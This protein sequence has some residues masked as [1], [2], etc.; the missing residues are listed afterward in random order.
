M[1]SVLTARRPRLTDAVTVAD[2]Y[3]RHRGADGPRSRQRTGPD[4]PAPR[5]PRRR[6][7]RSSSSRMRP[8]I[9]PRST[10]R[11]PSPLHASGGRPVPAV[12]LPWLPGPDRAP[13]RP[14]RIHVPTRRPGWRTA[15]SRT[16]SASTPSCPAT[17]GSRRPPVRQRARAWGTMRPASI[18]ALRGFFHPQRS[19]DD[20]LGRPARLRPRDARRDPRPAAS[21]RSSSRRS[22]VRDARR[23][24]LAAAA[25]PGRPHG[26]HA[27][28]RPRRRR[29]DV[30]GIVDFG[31]MSHGAVVDL[32]SV[33]DSLVNGRK[34]D[35][36]FRRAR[37]CSRVRARSPL[38]PLELEVLP[39]L[40][41]RG[42]PRSDRDPVLARRRRA[43]RTPLR[44]AI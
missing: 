37:S 13:A 23:A 22:T 11:R 33:L 14:P 36:L 6:R 9:R 39:E 34:D 8:R 21:R 27:R 4:V 10:W 16:T 40:P 20:A 12:A 29:R 41:W 32:A 24:G 19:A 30:T 28:Q 43:S 17:A 2:R 3:V 25:R 44:R 1:D 5:R 38:E 35:E 42:P 18:V 15:T 7:W 31:D 26:S